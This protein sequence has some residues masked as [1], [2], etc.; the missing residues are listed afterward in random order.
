MFSEAFLE[1]C[2]SRLV[3]TL[4]LGG[5]TCLANPGSQTEFT[6]AHVADVTGLAHRCSA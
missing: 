4:L 6:A 1:R 5:A 2:A 3:A